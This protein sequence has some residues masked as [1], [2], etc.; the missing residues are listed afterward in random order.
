MTDQII[1]RGRI[2]AYKIRYFNGNWSGWYVPGVNDLSDVY[3]PYSKKMS[4]AV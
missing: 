2:A 4:F 3:N 1:E